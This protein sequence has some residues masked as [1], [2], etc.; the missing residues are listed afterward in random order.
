MRTLTVKDL[1]K[2]LEDI[3]GS[4]AQIKAAASMVGFNVDA[5]TDTYLERADQRIRVNIHQRGRINTLK[6]LIEDLTESP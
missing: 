1:E 6:S 4:N 3:E 5:E 2:Y